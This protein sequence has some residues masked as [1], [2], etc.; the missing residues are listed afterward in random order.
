MAWMTRRASASGLASAAVSGRAGGRSGRASPAFAG[1][2][3]STEEP[4]VAH[5][6]RT[7]VRSRATVHAALLVS[8]VVIATPLGASLRL[9]ARP[10][11]RP[12]VRSVECTYVR[13]VV[14]ERIEELR[15]DVRRI[16][17]RQASLGMEFWRCL[18]ERIVQLRID[19]IQDLQSVEPLR[20]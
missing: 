15:R 2:C 5:A 12:V 10:P 7:T 3:G 20:G 4:T 11:S 16:E 19:L 17:G 14:E 8:G 6:C 18:V 9:E 13:S 1:D